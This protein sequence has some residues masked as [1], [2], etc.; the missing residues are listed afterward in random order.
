MIIRMLTPLKARDT[1][2]GFKL[3]PAKLA[4]KYF[5]ELQT[6]G[7]AHDV[8]LLYNAYLHGNEIKEMPIT[9]TAIEGSKI[10]LFRDGYNMLMEVLKI[11]VKTKQRFREGKI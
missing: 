9:W 1:Q 5:S 2:C 10:R 3:Y 6:Y 11:V 8:E 4:R 7:W